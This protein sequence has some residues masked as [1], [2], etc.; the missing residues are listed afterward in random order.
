MGG[1]TE[2]FRGALGC[3]TEEDPGDPQVGLG[4]DLGGL[5]RSRRACFSAALRENGSRR[6]GTGGKVQ[7]GIP[8]APSIG[9]PLADPEMQLAIPTPALH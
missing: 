1:G 3:R 7:L 4:G 9:R 6:P 5:R 2:R 8:K